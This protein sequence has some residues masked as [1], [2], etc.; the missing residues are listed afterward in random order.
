MNMLRGGILVESIE[1]RVGPSDA[2]PSVSLPGYDPNR[3]KIESI[4]EARQ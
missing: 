2:S 4:K 3:I 1:P